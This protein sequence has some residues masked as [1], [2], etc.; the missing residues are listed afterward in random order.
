VVRLYD[1]YCDHWRNRYIEGPLIG[2]VV[3]FVLQETLANYGTWYL[4]LLGLVAAGSAIWLPR[5]CGVESSTGWAYACSGPATRSERRVRHQWRSA[6]EARTG[7]DHRGGTGG[8]PSLAPAR[9]AG[10]RIGD[11]GEPQREYCEQR[12]RAGLLEHGTVKL[13]RAHGLGARLDRQGIEHGG[14][15]LQFDGERHRLDFRELAGE[16]VTIY[17]QTEIVKDLIAARLAAGQ[18]LSF[19]ASSTAVRDLDSAPVLSYVDSSG[20]LN[21]VACEVIAD[22][23]ASTGCPGRRCRHR[24]CGPTNGTIVRVAGRHRGGGAVDRRS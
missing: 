21:E 1:L 16:T 7:R 4:I 2:A 12:Q 18:D 8:S 24:C 13:L 14:I 5:G 23:T 17:A 11:R 20:V 22:A 15:Y 9:R 6:R 19:S 3:F 10:R